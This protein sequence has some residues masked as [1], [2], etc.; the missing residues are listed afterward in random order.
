MSAVAIM[1][2][3]FFNDL[4]PDEFGIFFHAWITLFRITCGNGSHK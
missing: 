2:V 4:S 3:T 1:G